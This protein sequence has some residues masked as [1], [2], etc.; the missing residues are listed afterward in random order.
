[1]LALLLL[2][3]TALLSL[4]VVMLRRSRPVAPPHL[5]TMRVPLIDSRDLERARYRALVENVDV[6]PFEYNPSSDKILY[7][8]PHV[9]QLF[10][11]GST[12]RM[13]REFLRA[14]IH[15][16]D[17]ARVR[18]AIH[19]YADGG[20]SE[21]IEYRLVRDDGKVVY[22]RTLLGDRT[23]DGTLVRGITLDTT[24]QTKLQ[25]ELRQAQKLQSVGRLAAGV[26]H[27]IN[28]PVQYVQD[29]VQF[30]RESIG[31]LFTV[32]EHHRAV[33]RSVLDGTSSI[34]LAQKAAAADEQ[35]DLGYLTEQVPPSLDRAF[36]GLE[37]VA[38]IVRS[39]KAF[40]HPEGMDRAAID[41]NAGISNTLEI[42][43]SEYKYVADVELDLGELPPV[44]CHGSEINQVILN[45][46][47]NAAHAIGNVVAGTGR[48]GTI[49]IKTRK[50]DSSAEIVISDTGAGIP[51]AIRDS[52]FDPFFTTKGV[53]HGSGQ[54]LAIARSVIA[55]KHG[56]TLTF[57][58][59]I[60][61]GTTF[62]IRLP[63][64]T[65]VFS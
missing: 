54:G 13:R 19:G 65:P 58:S 39:M 52:I 40:A 20:P 21:A 2:A 26:A 1:M 28:T 29:S 9:K 63:L 59:A 25:A 6:I 5:P 62:T 8:A 35:S 55:E 60:G 57:E 46:V 16:D 31:E 36:D 51:D 18:E 38:T 44:P 56:G 61:V 14:M 4:L 45:V 12:T 49:S 30:L 7:V 22:V 41:L 24:K 47:V 48:R 23:D 27:E 64:E 3:Q 11:S 42:A 33:T 10:G 32:I 50:V 34:E 15:P 17:R 37:R 53:G 43:R